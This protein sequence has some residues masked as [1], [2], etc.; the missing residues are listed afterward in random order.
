MKNREY[1]D[2]IE[3]ILT[4]VNDIE[5]FTKGMDF[6][7]FTRDRKTVF[8]VIRGIEVIGEAYSKLS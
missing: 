7:D 1:G 4:S 2:Y 8:A 5:E 6:D 3:D